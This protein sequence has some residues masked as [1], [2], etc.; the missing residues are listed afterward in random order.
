LGAEEGI[1]E[2]GL[3]ADFDAQGMDGMNG[4]RHGLKGGHGCWVVMR[5]SSN[6]LGGGR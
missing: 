2:P 5:I 4:V 3:P 1:A 6:R